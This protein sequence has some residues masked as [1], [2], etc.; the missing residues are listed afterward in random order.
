[1]PT[2]R[3][4]A[5]VGDLPQAHLLPPDP[6]TPADDVGEEHQNC[7]VAWCVGLTLWLHHRSDVVGTTGS[8]LLSPLPQ[9]R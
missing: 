5:R 8:V 2:Y 9:V 3:C 1:M 6:A 4:G 7:L